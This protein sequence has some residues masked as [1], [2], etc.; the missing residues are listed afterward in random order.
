MLEGYRN[1][2]RAVDQAVVKL[3]GTLG[4]SRLDL[5]R[6]AGKSTPSI[7]AKLQREKTLRLSQMQD[8]AGCRIIVDYLSEQNEIVRRL[9]RKLPSSSVDDRRLRP[10]FGYRAVHVIV[11]HGGLP[12]EVQVRTDAQDLWAQLVEKLS[13][14][15]YPSLKYG[16]GP[17]DLVAEIMSLSDREAEFDEAKNRLSRLE[18]A[19]SGAKSSSRALVTPAMVSGAQRLTD[20]IARELDSRFEKLGGL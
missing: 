4:Q 17:P 2:F 18:R 11:K 5:S 14:S 6:R 9:T 7:V 12:Y 13:D 15:A 10:S 20:R 8:I 19:N 16:E 1:E 3:I